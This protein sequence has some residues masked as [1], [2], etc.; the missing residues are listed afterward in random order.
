MPGARTESWTANST[1]DA[2]R[3]RRSRSRDRA[4][5][6]SP[7]RSRRAATTYRLDDAAVPG[8]VQQMRGAWP[9][10]SA[11]LVDSGRPSRDLDPVRRAVDDGRSPGGYLLAGSAAPKIRRPQR[12][13]ADHLAAYGFDDAGG[14]RRRPTDRRSLRELLGNAAPSAEARRNCERYAHESSPRACR[15]AQH[16]RARR[17]RPVDGYLDA[18]SIMISRSSARWSNQAALRRSMAGYA[19]ARSSAASYQKSGRCEHGQ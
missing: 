13:G 7:S 5:S 12:R 14:T 15:S 18:S 6:A 3:R 1:S 19:S 10:A 17:P 9:A 8:M 4:V 11:I 16:S 2:R